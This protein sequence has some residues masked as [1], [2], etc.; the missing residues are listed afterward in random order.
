MQIA[1]GQILFRGTRIN[2]AQTTTTT[3]WRIPQLKKCRLVAAHLYL[4]AMGMIVNAEPAPNPAAKPRG[5]QTI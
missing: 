4:I 2:K 1:A 5:Q 3:P